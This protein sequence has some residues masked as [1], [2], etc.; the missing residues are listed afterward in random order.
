MKKTLAFKMKLKPG[1]KEEYTERHNKIWPELKNLL[2]QYGVC[3]YFIYL[4]EETDTLFA[5]QKVVGDMNSQELG[6]Y[7]IV[8]KWW[9]YMSDIMETNE[10]LSPISQ[11]LE[12]VF[13]M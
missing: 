1:M 11:P 13:N 12:E 6:H 5:F 10:D 4:D 9:K 8:K 7:Q 3:E 2:E